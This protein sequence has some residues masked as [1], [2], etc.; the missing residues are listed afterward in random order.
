MSNKRFLLMFR[1]GRCLH[2]L[3]SDLKVIDVVLSSSGTSFNLP[4]RSYKL[5][6]QSFVNRCPFRDCC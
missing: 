5:Y 1:S 3:L 6:K 2:T 4:H